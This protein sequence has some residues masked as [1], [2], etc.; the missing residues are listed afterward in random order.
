MIGSEG[1]LEKLRK[2]KIQESGENIIMGKMSTGLLSRVGLITQFPVGIKEE[3][4]CR[5]RDSEI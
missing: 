3:M 5:E 2:G 1:L 4:W